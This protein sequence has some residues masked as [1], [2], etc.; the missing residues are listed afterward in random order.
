[1]EWASEGRNGMTTHRGVPIKLWS[2]AVSE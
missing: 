1:M 2:E